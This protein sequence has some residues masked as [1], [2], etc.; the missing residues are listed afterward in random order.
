ML[1]SLATLLTTR[2][3]QPAPDHTRE[4][5]TSLTPPPSDMREA[6]LL[7]AAFREL[8]GAGLH[9]FALLL[10][11]GDRSRAA[12]IAS[13]TLAEGAAR[14]G[15]LRH[16]ERA[17]AW[18]R[19][20]VV[21]AVRRT[22]E[23]RRHSRSERRAVLLELGVPEPAI[24]TLEGMSLDAR[25]AVVASSVERFALVD[26]ATVLDRDLEATRRLLRDARRRYLSDAMHW[27]S[28]VPREGLGGG[29]IAARV[30]EAAARALGRLGSAEGMA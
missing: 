1:D 7:R 14:V 18:L 28:T 5:P 24:A 8:H 21:R 26:V 3:P 16:P 27:L 11:V 20:R 25:A 23:S 17:A 19:A 6:D 29:A 15:D 4:V 10:T 9:G 12:S 22:A 13:M 2:A 30:D